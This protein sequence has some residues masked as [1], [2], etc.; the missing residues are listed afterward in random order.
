MEFQLVL[1]NFSNFVFTY[2]FIFMLV[3][4]FVKRKDENGNPNFM[5]KIMTCC[6][7]VFIGIVFLFIFS[8]GLYYFHPETKFK[9]GDKEFIFKV[10][11][12]STKKE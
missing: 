7:G 12:N 1:S 2:L 5:S 8:A 3:E 4:I 6:L 10:V 11:G 9:V